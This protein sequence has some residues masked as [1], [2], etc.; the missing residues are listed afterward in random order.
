MLFERRLVPVDSPLAIA[1]CMI[2]SVVPAFLIGIILVMPFVSNPIDAYVALF[3]A[4]FGSLRGFG[5]TL[6]RA[7]PLILVALGTCVA[8]RSGFGYLGFEG[9]LTLGAAAATWYALLALDG[10]VIASM[11]FLAFL[12]IASILAFLAG[13][14]WAGGVG[15][16]RSR[17]GGNEVLIS[18]MANYVAV[19]I[20]QFLVSGPMRAAGNLPETT[21]LP[22]IIPGTRTHA[23]ILIA[24]LAAAAIWLLMSRMRLGYEFVVTGLNP[25]AA[26]YGGINVGQRYV[27]AAVFAGGVAALAGLVEVLGTQHRLLDGL[28]G[29]MGFLG[30]VVAL[31]AKLNPLAVVPIAILYAAL[32]VGADAMQRSTGA[33]SSIIFI[34]QSLILLS[35]IASDF[36]RY[37][38]IR[39]P[40]MS[41]SQMGRVKDA[42]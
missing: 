5:I 26:R 18:L 11:P 28:S 16:L 12:F 6:N 4:S 39:P 13:G 24:L 31:H 17:F 40:M 7:T 3:D 23:G 1:G 9:C 21:W 33:P 15:V 19:L 29:G 8:W 35:V 20:V 14:A 30:I 36:L 41:R 10:G 37:W 2:G 32:S 34:L 38:T 42:G 27:L 25:R 22:I